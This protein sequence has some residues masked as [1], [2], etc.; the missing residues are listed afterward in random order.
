MLRSAIEENDDGVVAGGMPH[1]SGV[2]EKNADVFLERKPFKEEQ[3]Q[4]GRENE[5]CAGFQSPPATSVHP[6]QTM[7]P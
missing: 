5:P 7:E 3:G 4:R 1:R 6:E 2:C